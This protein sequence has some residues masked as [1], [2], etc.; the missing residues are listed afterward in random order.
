[1]T[2]AEATE[3]FKKV[4]GKKIAKNWWPKG[5]Y[6]IPESLV[7]GTKIGMRG[8]LYGFNKL[9]NNGILS[10]RNGLGLGRNEWSFTYEGGA[11]EYTPD[12]PI[13]VEE[14]AYQPTLGWGD[15]N[16]CSCDMRVLMMKGCQ[17][18]AIE[19]ERRA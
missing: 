2:L 18:G 8:N 11:L 10:I 3:F 5:D 16:T 6:F 19:R 1:M 15:D 14:S 12:Q 7:V 9:Y 17:C 4:E 13:M